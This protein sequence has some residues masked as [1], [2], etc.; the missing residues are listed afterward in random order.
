MIQ[1][2]FVEQGVRAQVG[3][4]EACSCIPPRTN[5]KASAKRNHRVSV[6]VKEKDTGTWAQLGTGKAQARILNGRVGGS[7]S[8]FSAE[9]SLAEATVGPFTGRLGAK[10][11]ADRDGLHLGA[12]SI[13]KFW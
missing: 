10:V 1:N 3:T 2:K 9:A 5:P 11:G 4:S 7:N 8:G 12:F 13:G 6:E